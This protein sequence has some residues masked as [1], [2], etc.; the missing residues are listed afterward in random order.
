MIGGSCGSGS[1]SGRVTI[2]STRLILLLPARFHVN[3]HVHV[4]VPLQPSAPIITV[5]WGGVGN[6]D[7]DGNGDT[8]PLDQVS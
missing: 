6:W 8:L 5:V 1:G 2:C 7:E 4:L 3:V